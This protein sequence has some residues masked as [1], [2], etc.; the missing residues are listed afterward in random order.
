MV[1][2][3][4]LFSRYTV[5]SEEIKRLEWRRA[6]VA[7]QLYETLSSIPQ[8]D[9][10][11]YSEVIPEFGFIVSLTEQQLLDNKNG[12][13]ALVSKVYNELTHVLDMKLLEYEEALRK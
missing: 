4:Q 2:I 11:R 13:L 1:D 6:E 8:E 12:E 10:R 3:K 5:V 7:K 9:I